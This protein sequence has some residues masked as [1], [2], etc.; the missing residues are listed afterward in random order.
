M[1][2]DINKGVVACGVRNRIYA[3]KE[4]RY[5]ERMLCLVWPFGVDSFEKL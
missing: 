2:G 5:N 1:I 3:E 4:T